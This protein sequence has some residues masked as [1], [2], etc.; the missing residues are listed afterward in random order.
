MTLSNMEEIWKE[1]KGYPN[2]MVSNFG[3]VKSLNYNHTSKEKMLKVSMNGNGYLRVLLC[4]NGKRK[5]M[6]VH[7]IVAET[8]IPNPDNKPCIDHIN[9]IKDDNRM[10]NLIWCTTKENCNNLLTLNKK[11]ES[12]K[13]EKHHFYGKQLSEGHRKK[14]SEKLSKTIKQIDIATN[15]II[16][17]FPSIQEIKRKL[18]YAPSL[19]CSCCNGKCKQAYGFKW[20]IDTDTT[21]NGCNEQKQPNKVV[22]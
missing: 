21:E 6:T 3:R 9:T 13:G 14:I 2:Y 20:E 1:I 7:R 11:S 15:E 8:F 10:E 22:T 19:I 16:A 12:R 5:H 4:N 17:I 18:G